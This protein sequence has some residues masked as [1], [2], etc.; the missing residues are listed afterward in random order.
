[1]QL[2]DG[3]S[4]NPFSST[5]INIGNNGALVSNVY[6]SQTYN[7]SISNN[8]ALVSNVSSGGQ[9]TYNGSISGAGSLTLAGSGN[10]NLYGSNTFT[11]PTF[12]N[13][14]NL[15][16][17]NSGAL[18]ASTVTPTTGGL[19]VL[20]VSG[21]FGGLSGSGFVDLWNGDLTVG[22]NNA[23]TTYSG[24]IYDSHSLKKVG[25]GTLTLTGSNAYTG[26]TTITG[27]TLQLGDGTGGHDPRLP[28]AASSITPH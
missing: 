8:G 21:S 25:S 6:N 4:D 27:G 23:N 26:S 1:M 9:Q 14:G 20:C 17:H 11:G 18:Q 10:L 16:V 24:L 3:I 19:V 2:G 22:D 28:A 5:S 7:G 13:G 15:N 12:V